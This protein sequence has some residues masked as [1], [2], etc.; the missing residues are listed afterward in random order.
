MQ[1]FAKVTVESKLPDF[2]VEFFDCSEPLYF[3]IK[4]GK[5]SFL[6]LDNYALSTVL[7]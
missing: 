2:L 7:K 5:F 6:G 1:N 4:H 3:I